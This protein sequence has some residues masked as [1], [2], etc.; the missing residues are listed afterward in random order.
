MTALASPSPLIA[1]ATAT[2]AAAAATDE[3]GLAAALLNGFRARS[4][5]GDGVTRPAYSPAET[6][7]MAL[8]A[9]TARAHGLLPHSDAVGNLWLSPP[10]LGD[11]G[12]PATGSHI[13][14]VPRGGNFDGA[15]GVVAGLICAIRAATEGWPLRGL[16]LRAEESPWFGAPHIGARAAFGAL[17]QAELATLRRDTGRSLADHMLAV[18]A[19]P[20]AAAAGR[21][22]P[23]IDRMAAFYELHI[24]QGPELVDRDLAATAVNSV[25]GHVRFPRATCTG[26]AGH[27]GTVPRHLRRDPVMA[28]AELLQ[29]LDILW[30]RSMQAGADLVITAGM[31]QVDPANASPTRIPDRVAFSLDVRSSQHETL[32][33]IL[34]TLARDCAAIGRR[35]GVVFDLGPLVRTDPVALD[36]AALAGLV[37]ELPGIVLNSGAGHDAAEFARR[38]KPAA[39]VFVRNRNGSHNPHEAMDIGDLM[40]GTDAMY[41]ALRTAWG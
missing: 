8:V 4:A 35:R 18:G 38:G 34:Q 39:M 12:A 33:A 1:T 11:A 30:E 2:A 9:E 13:D 22:L 17:D 36:R 3:P 41:R 29:D 7:C 19:D 10:G 15:A 25:R 21:P 24:E 28:T 37:R 23:E 31:M 32:D 20:H 6:A 27:S 26:E 5:D 14:S 16:V 40:T